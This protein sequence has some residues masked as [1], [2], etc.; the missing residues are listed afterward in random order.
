MENKPEPPISERTRLL[1]KL[2]KQRMNNVKNDAFTELQNTQ[3]IAIND[4]EHSNY[5]TSS[6]EICAINSVTSTAVFCT[7]RTEIDASIS[8]I[9]PENVTR[10]PETD[11]YISNLEPENLK[12]MR[13]PHNFITVAQCLVFCLVGT[14]AS[15]VDPVVS[16]SD[17]N[18]QFDDSDEDPNYSAS[19]SSS[20]SSS[21]DELSGPPIEGS[22]AVNQ[23]EGNKN[24]NVQNSRK[25][26]V[27]PAAWKK[28]VAKRCRTSGLEYISSSKS[29]KVFKAKSLGPPCN[30]K[31][32]LQCYSKIAEE[33]RKT[34]FSD[35][36]KLSD[37]Q[38]QRDFLLKCIETITP[39]YQYKRLNSK[40]ASNHA[41]YFSIRDT[42]FR[43][44]KMFFKSTLAITDRPIRTVIQKQTLITTKGIITPEN[45]GKHY[46]H[47]H[48]DNDVKNGVRMHINSVP[49]IESH[50]CRKDSSREY[51]EGGKTV[52]QL[53]RDY[54]AICKESNKPY[55]NYLM[56]CRIFND[57]FKIS[58][59][60]PKKDQCGDCVSYEIASAEVKETLKDDYDTHL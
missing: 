41:F 11:T 20:S 40:R 26:K 43:V 18:S 59:H 1:L 16:D 50:Y 27:D 25:R 58:F 31:C 51:I 35:Y 39:Q 30:E 47:Y 17:S 54:V 14:S 29:K 3:W 15:V 6:S 33:D 2:S 13:Q 8:N 37:L 10:D 36:W 32:R 9:Y 23:I 34:N 60:T 19:S 38:R 56:Y 55:A 24:Q 42:K 45:R 49:R 28:A 7:E 4:Y 22:P 21:E 12:G 57:E 5:A 53:H 52:A 46:H 44:C 48:I